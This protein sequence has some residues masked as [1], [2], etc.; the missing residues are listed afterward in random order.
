L[1]PGLF[2]ESAKKNKKGRDKES[3]KKNSNKS[4][5]ERDTNTQI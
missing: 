2:S 3:K 5:K 4:S 1:V